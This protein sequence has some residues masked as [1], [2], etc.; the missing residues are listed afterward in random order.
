VK[1][2]NLGISRGAD[3]SKHLDLQ[4]HG[5]IDGGW[6]DDGIGVNSAEI[7]SELQKHLDAKTIGGRINSIGGSAFAGI[8]MYNALQSHPAEVTMT[9]E[10]LAAS[11]ASLVAMAGKTVMGRGAMMMIH[12]P[13]AAVFGN[14]TDLRKAADWLDKVQTG[15]ASIYV[16]KTGKSL[17]AVNKLIDAETWMTA[18]EAVASGFADSVG[19]PSPVSAEPRMTSDGVVWQGVKFPA[20]LMPER[21]LNMAKE[22]APPAPAAPQSPVVTVAAPAVAVPPVNTIDPRALNRE[23]MAKEAPALLAA[24]LDEGRAAGAA[25]ERERLKAI[26]ELGLKGCDELVNAAKYGDKPSDA[27][28]LAVAAIKAGKQAGADLLAARER[29]SQAAA[30]VKQSAPTKSTEDAEMA[31]AKNIAEHANRR[32]GGAR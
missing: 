2:W 4:I 15:I 19:G 9:V 10:G 20:A 1:V 18:D 6:M 3:G 8:A 27:R 16:E 31:A 30:G 24:L 13:S 25:A 29:E 11:A 17:N 14:A 5:V 12:P 22:I 28:D 26:D 32:H 23:V 21:V 7:I